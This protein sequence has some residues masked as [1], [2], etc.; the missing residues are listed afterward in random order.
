[1]VDV[2]NTVLWNDPTSGIEI[3]SPC[4]PSRPS[5]TSV[6]VGGTGVTPVVVAASNGMAQPGSA[7]CC[8]VSSSAGSSPSPASIA[9]PASATDARSARCLI[10]VVEVVMPAHAELAPKTHS[11]DSVPHREPHDPD[12]AIGEIDVH[13]P[14]PRREVVGRQ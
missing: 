5:T 14:G 1:S 13:L 8:S 12:L 9:Q 10:R 7:S 4:Q 2:L 11:R 6:C 3:Q